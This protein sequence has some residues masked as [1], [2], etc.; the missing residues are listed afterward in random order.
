MYTE[1]VSH[2]LSNAFRAKTSEEGVCVA[3]VGEGKG[4][5]VVVVLEGEA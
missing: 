3:G 1:G 2:A 4:A 5:E